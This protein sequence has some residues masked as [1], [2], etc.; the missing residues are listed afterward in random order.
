MQNVELAI[1]AIAPPFDIHGTSVVLFDDDG[2]SPQLGDLGIGDGEAPP[3]PFFD[4]ESAHGAPGFA[5]IGKYHFD[6]FGSQ[7]SPQNRGAPGVKRRFVDI[8]LIGIDRTLHH[9]LAQAVGGRD[10]HDLIETRFRVQREHHT[11]GSKIAADHA[12]HAGG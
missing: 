9:G 1:P 7:G 12:L 2:K 3:L 5:R 10:E 4:V 8:E 6:E 11:A